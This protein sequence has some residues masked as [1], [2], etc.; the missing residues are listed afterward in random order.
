MQIESRINIITIMYGRVCVVC[1][2]TDKKDRLCTGSLV[3]QRLLTARRVGAGVGNVWEGG[4]R[5]VGGLVYATCSTFL[6]NCD[7]VV[8]CINI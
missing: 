3:S 8:N 4:G 1:T 7:H 6:F 5:R 2:I